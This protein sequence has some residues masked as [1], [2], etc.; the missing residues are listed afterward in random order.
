MAICERCK[1]TGWY[2]YDNNHST[3]CS[4]CCPHNQGWW[5]LT[6]DYQ[7][8]K[9]GKDN[10]CCSCGCGTMRRDVEGKK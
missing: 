5:I 7:G 3:V 9:E 1:G 4:D 2:M 6:K 10:A 8:Y